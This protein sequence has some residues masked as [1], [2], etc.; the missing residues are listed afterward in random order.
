MRTLLLLAIG[1]AGTLAVRSQTIFSVGSSS[2]LTIKNGTI[3][4]ANGLVLTPGSDFTLSS[5]NVAKSS[6]AVTVSPAPGI[7]R[8]Y[9]WGS[10][11]TFTGTIQLYYQLSEL[12]GNP[13]SALQYTD[14]AIGGTWLA[15][16]SSSVNTTSHYVQQSATARNFIGATAS[17]QGTVLALSLISFTGAWDGDQA[18][19]AWVINQSNEVADFTVDRSMDG[20]TWTTIGAV[21][22]Q[23]GDGLKSYNFSDANPPAGTVLYRLELHRSSGQTF[24]SSIVKLQRGD[25]SRI[26]L[27]TQAKSVIVYFDG[28]QPAAVRVVNAGGVL[29]RV[30]MTS[31]PRYEFSGLA[32]GIYYLQYEGNGQTGVRSFLID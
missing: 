32:A 27:V 28:V 24:Y 13:E 2:A 21:N 14:S 5:N 25:D 7:N 3:F 12:N 19:L 4:D 15:S 18:G 20:I 8:V 6:T 31:R 9:T 10:Q 30:D 26:R 22:G 16:A 29:M 1:L 11:I 23:P 17:H